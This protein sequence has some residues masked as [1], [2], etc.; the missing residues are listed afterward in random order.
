MTNDRPKIRSTVGGMQL[1]DQLRGWQATLLTGLQTNAARGSSS[2]APH[3]RPIRH[4]LV[5]LP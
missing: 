2:V 3:I 5:L 4:Q 1:R